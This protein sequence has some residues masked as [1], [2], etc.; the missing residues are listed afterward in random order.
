MIQND[1]HLHTTCSDGTLAP[2]ELVQ[3]CAERGLKVIAISDHDSTE[4]VEEALDAARAF[5][6]LEVIPG[7]ELSTDVPGSEIHMLGYFVDH[8]DAAFQRILTEFREGRQQRTQQ[9]VER[10]NE[11]G[12][13]ISLERVKELSKGGAIGRPHI[14]QAMVEA[15]YVKY[16]R[17]AF[18]RYIGR[19]G[20]AYAER[21]KLTPVEAINIL[22]GHGAV[23]VMA[24]P[25]YAASK[26]D[27]DGVASLRDILSELKTA[28]LAGMEVYYADYTTEQV[29]WLAGLADDVG[30]IPCGG[31][32]YHASGNPGESEPGS[33]GPATESVERLRSLSLAGPRPG[34]TPPTAQR[35]GG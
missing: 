7:V 25:T 11:L 3:L 26:S 29:E 31:S 28:G 22:V 9:M 10:L 4:G 24:H 32:D 12:I 20:V 15:G 18:D 6:E 2:K 23:P 1:L 8:R 13:D 21:V 14:A 30:L 19:N 33:V 5:P 34:P 16:P 35:S 17:D 27:R